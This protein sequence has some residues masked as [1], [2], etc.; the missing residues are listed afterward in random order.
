[1]SILFDKNCLWNAIQILA[2]EW[3]SK[4]PFSYIR[5]LYD[6]GWAGSGALSGA[7]SPGMTT[8]SGTALDAAEEAALIHAVSNSM[9]A[10]IIGL[11]RF[12]IIGLRSSRLPFVGWAAPSLKIGRVVGCSIPAGFS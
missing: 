1:M 11:I 10:E 6:P 8:G 5:D 7:L 2:T 4:R 12:K 3:H 9:S